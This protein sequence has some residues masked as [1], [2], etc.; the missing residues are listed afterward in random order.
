MK[1]TLQFYY[2]LAVCALVV[3][4]GATDVGAQL[5]QYYNN[6]GSTTSTNAFPWSTGTG[7][8]IQWIVNSGEFASPVPAPAGHN[9]TE[10]WFYAASTINATYTNFSVKMGQIPSNTDAAWTAASMYTGTMTTV[11]NPASKVLNVATGAWFSMTLDVPFFY[12]PSQALIVEVS[13][14]GFTGTSAQSASTFTASGT[15]RK[16]L[17]PATTTPCTQAYSGQDALMSPI[18]LT[19]VSAGPCTAPP[20]AGS[21]LA[22]NASPCF[23]QSVSLNLLGNSTGGGQTYQWESSSSLSGPWI[24]EGTSLTSPYLVVTPP[25]GTTYYRCMVTCGSSSVASVADTVIVATPFPGGV[26]TI[27]SAVAT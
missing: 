16:Y 9:I 11:I 2:R 5:P 12:D 6:A 19:L 27:N 23:G 4:F 13:Q 17:N 18:G 24:P 15:R 3:L 22:S 21:A 1:K 8:G 10:V 7:K 20:A 14:C 26:Y 25:V